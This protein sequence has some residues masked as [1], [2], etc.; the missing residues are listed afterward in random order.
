MR[1]DQTSLCVPCRVRFAASDR[2][3]RCGGEALD[4]TSPEARERARALL[5]EVPRR[6]P[7]WVRRLVP[8]PGCVLAA[9][10]TVIV[11]ATFAGMGFGS[12]LGGWA[13]MAA[14]FVVPTVA[15]IVWVL[16]LGRAWDR[17][18]PRLAEL[19]GEPAAEGLMILPAGARPPTPLP[20][21][22][23]HA[24]ELEAPPDRKIVEGR[25][26]VTAPVHSPLTGLEHAA[27][28]VVGSH[29]GAAIDDA[30]IGAFTIE[31]DDGVVTRVTG[32]A[33]SVALETPAPAPVAWTAE[34]ASFLEPRTLADAGEEVRTAEGAL[35]DGDRVV[36]EGVVREVPRPDG[37]RGA[38]TELVFDDASLVIRSVRAQSA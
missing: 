13:V 28:R 2:C 29:G 26:R 38:R 21:I 8:S 17:L 14:F 11:L 31:S 10:L 5:R 27:F 22:A 1:T 25:L 20:A 4:L 18:M 6:A 3:P 23:L 34:L 7:A 37:Y 9:V 16:L 15:T 19:R 32:G 12:L 30:A 36:V 35:R 24:M 33:G